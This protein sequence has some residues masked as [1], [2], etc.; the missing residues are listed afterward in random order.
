M[1]PKQL[2]TFLAAAIP[3]RLPVLITGAPGVGKSD[4]VEQSTLASNADLLLSHPAVSD[5]TDAKG[6]PWP[7]K[8]ESEATFL[9]FG[10]L[11]RALKAT[12]PTVWFL[13]DLGQASPAVQ[14][15]YMQ[16]LLA[17]RVNGHVLPDCVTF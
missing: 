6:L 17:R 2:S 8:G 13:D 1:N 14:A 7:K 3:A 10:E 15:S 12:K 4:I 16:L 9:P 5:P 11:A